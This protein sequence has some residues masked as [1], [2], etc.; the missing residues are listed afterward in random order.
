MRDKKR[1]RSLAAWA[2]A[3]SMAMGNSG[4]MV[5]AES[6]DGGWVAEDEFTAYPEDTQPEIVQEEDQQEAVSAETGAEVGAES[7]ELESAEISDFG[8][9]MEASGFEAGEETA[10]DF[11]SD[12]TEEI[13]AF[14]DD[15]DEEEEGEEREGYFIEVFW[16][17]QTNKVNTNNGADIPIGV[18]YEWNEDGRHYAK[19]I[20]DYTLKL[21]DGEDG[22]LYDSEYISE[23]EITESS[24]PGRKYLS[25][26]TKENPGTVQFSLEAVVDNEEKTTIGQKIEIEICDLYYKLMPEGLDTPEVG[27]EL[28]FSGLYVEV[29]GGDSEDGSDQP[30]ENVEY[31][32]DDYNRDVLQVEEDENG[33]PVSVRRISP[34]DGWI[35]FV[36]YVKNEE[37]D[38]EEIC[39]RSYGIS[40]LEYP[41]WFDSDRDEIFNDEENFEVPL[42]VEELEN[43]DVEIQWQIGYSDNAYDW[44]DDQSFTEISENDVEKFWN[45]D[46]DA[47]VLTV[48]GEKLAA[49]YEWLRDNFGEEYK[50]AARVFVMV[51]TGNEDEQIE[52]NRCQIALNTRETVYDYHLDEYNEWQMMVDEGLWI[53]RIGDCWVEN[54]ENWDGGNLPYEITSVSVENA[55]GEGDTPVCSVKENKYG[56]DVIAEHP[57][58]AILTI[59]YKDLNEEEQS[60]SGNIHVD[61][62]IYYLEVNYSDDDNRMLTNDV[63][64]ANLSLH[65]QWAYS[66]E[67]RGDETVR[68]F[69]VE[70]LPDQNGN[71]Y[72]ED[73]IYVPY[74]DRG[75]SEPDKWF[76]RIESKDREGMDQLYGTGKC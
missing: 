68:D 51:N 24:Q 72:D 76:L 48:N 20:E 49:A 7:A 35:T 23:A 28:D 3:F 4:V 44:S 39:R 57:G 65:H 66:E 70:L 60:F 27:S 54:A 33:I 6:T 58:A 9:E 47:E 21:I 14:T 50:F 36:A 10:E 32:V 56:W 62:D 22:E 64:E 61:K 45:I 71:C 31:W 5:M 15:N 55:E 53:N 37:G 41:I 18:V 46:Y 19:S 17:D 30:P 29:M 67:D 38:D 34:D 69:K 63:K 43:R 11:I 8:S 12:G 13:A 59:R 16:T 25:V 75:Y 40:E 1:W 74:V 26:S 42:N 73:V 2:L 52:L